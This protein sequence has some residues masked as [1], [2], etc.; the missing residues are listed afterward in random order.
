MQKKD[1]QTLI[2]TGLIG[3]LIGLG[4][5]F[6]RWYFVYKCNA[7]TGGNYG[8]KMCH[9]IYYGK[10]PAPVFSIMFGGLL[11]LLVFG[12]LVFCWMYIPQRIIRDFI[13]RKR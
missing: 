10:T 5:M 9:Y 1:K 3:M 6:K 12:V 13:N 2:I 8:Y 11:L 7:L 4:W